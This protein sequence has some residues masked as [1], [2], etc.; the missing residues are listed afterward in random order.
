MPAQ[1]T[2]PVEDTIAKVNDEVA[3]GS[4]LEFQRKWW[5]FTRLVWI[6]FPLIVV[7]DLLGCFGRGPLANARIQT[8]D[9]SLD[10]K[11][12]RIERFSSPSILRIQ[13]GPAAIH[14]GKIQLWM[15]ESLI[16]SLGNQRIIPQPAASA[17]GKNGVL[18]TFDATALPAASAFSLEPI[19][20]GIF[21]LRMHVPGCEELNLTIYVMP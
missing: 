13:F 21:H 4:D 9:G 7:A 20:P 19:K 6:V 15:D 12:E 18:Y 10:V 1:A 16:R 11:Y 8:R 17:I 5:R 3:V 2:K 14:D